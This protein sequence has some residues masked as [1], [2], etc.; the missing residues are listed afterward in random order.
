MGD[1][2]EMGFVLVRGILSLEEG[3]AARSSVSCL[4]NPIGQ[5]SL[6]GY[7]AGITQRWTRLNNYFLPETNI[8]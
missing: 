7:M 2:Q 6:A 5:T 1:A 4:E 3:V 8:F